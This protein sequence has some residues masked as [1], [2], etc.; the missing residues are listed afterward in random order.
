MAALTITAA[1]RREI[2]RFYG[3]HEPICNADVRSEY[4]MLVRKGSARI[5]GDIRL[6][7]L[8]DIFA[9]HGADPVHG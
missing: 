5:V 1:L 2:E 7:A 6:E 4:N 9:R 3:L 8:R